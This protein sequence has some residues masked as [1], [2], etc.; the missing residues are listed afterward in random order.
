METATGIVLPFST[1]N[2]KV[3]KQT[4]NKTI[5]FVAIAYTKTGDEA[6]FNSANDGAKFWNDQSGK[7]SYVV[8][9]GENKIVYTVNFDVTVKYVDNPGLQTNRDDDHSGIV[10][11]DEKITNGY[12]NSFELLPDNDAKFKKA[13]KVSSLAPQVKIQYTLKNHNQ[14]T[15]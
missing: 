1:L 11:S 4:E 15:K 14:E 5:I 3:Q 13:Q 6:A 10:P 2:L 9:Q 7:Y 8:G 12:G